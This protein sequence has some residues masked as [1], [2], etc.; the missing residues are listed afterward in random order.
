[1]PASAEHFGNFIVDR[2][3]KDKLRILLQNVN[4][5]GAVAK[6]RACKQRSL[7]LFF[8]FLNE[9]MVYISI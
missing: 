1:M 6:T 2:I 5:N 3:S 8:R 4:E 7:G 9:K